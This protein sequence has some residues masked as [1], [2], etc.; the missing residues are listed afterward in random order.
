MTQQYNEVTGPNAGAL[1]SMM[2]GILVITLYN[3]ERSHS[4][5]RGRRWIARRRRECDPL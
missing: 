4:W 2:D 3:S 5:H 1:I